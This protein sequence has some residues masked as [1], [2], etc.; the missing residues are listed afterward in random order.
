MNN[1]TKRFFSIAIIAIIPL[2]IFQVVVPTMAEDTTDE[3]AVYGTPVYDDEGYL[4][5]SNITIDISEES[6]PIENFTNIS[7]MAPSGCWCD[8]RWSG[9]DGVWCSKSKYNSN[10]KIV[11]YVQFKNYAQDCSYIINFRLYDPSG[12]CIEYKLEYGG[13]GYMAVQEYTYTPPAP[14]TG[15]YEFCSKVEP[16][17]C[18]GRVLEKC[19]TFT[20]FVPE[21][22][23]DL[24]IT[25]I[26]SENN[27]IYYKIKNKGD[28]KAGASITSLTV[29]GDFKAADSVASLDPG[30]E[31][32]E[33][34]NYTWDCTGTNDTIE[35]CADYTNDLMESNEENNCRTQTW[36]CEPPDIW[37]N[38]T[39]FDVRLPPD[40]VSNYTLTI[41][42]KGTGAL[43]FNVKDREQA[44]ADIV[45]SIPVPGTM[46]TGLTWD[47]QYLWLGDWLAQK[48]Y[49][50]NS[51]DGSII[52]SISITSLPLPARSCNGLAW[53]GG[54]LWF[55]DSLEQKIYKISTTGSL[56]TAFSAPG[57]VDGWGKGLTWDG[58]RLWHADFRM[59]TIYKLN[60]SNGAVITSFSSPANDPQGLAWDGQ[61]LWHSDSGS[62]MIYKLNPFDG[63]VITFFSAPGSEIG[64]LTWDGQY[65]WCNEG[66]TLK[67]YQIEVGGGVT[68]WL[69]EYP[70]SGTV[71]PGS[72]TNIN[73]TFNTT[74]LPFGESNADINITSND[75]DESVV[76]VPVH[77]EVVNPTKTFDTGAGSY[78]S[79]MGV[80]NGT[81]T[82]S[83]D[84]VVN[85]MYTY[86]CEGT[87]GHS[88][89]VE[90]YNKTFYVNA[91]WN[92]YQS[93]SH[94]I[95]FP[96]QFTL[97]AD[98]RYNYTII[99]GSYP[100]IIHEHIFNTTSD[101]E[102]TC[103][104]FID[105][106]GKRYDTWIPAIRLG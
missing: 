6:A 31:R 46:P 100:Q 102:I 3:N 73:I 69:S 41:G 86:A 35:V 105:A 68:D 15:R 64:D 18:D 79:I 21:L 27:T 92:G 24:M 66:S 22:K 5:T 75:P 26:W 58:Q 63:S 33:S 36:I 89:F 71:N 67:I 103:T 59:D 30:V 20:V 32:A 99:T 94:N 10:E 90:L 78:P 12:E 11:C 56:K 2:S 84:V 7:T 76:V 62:G 13:I 8:L 97:L 83:H 98:H 95:T 104:E 1:R 53:D 34:L 17:I 60:P 65:L 43:E 47:G 38:P 49:K 42:N 48:I 28:S 93:D 91:T 39:S 96:Q 23:P 70:I 101:G 85:K 25:N 44:T 45:K 61:Y 74:G 88:E 19:C 40:V 57:G 52:T 80:H 37:V 16:W 54:Y 72:Q 51:S 87:G 9:Q 81:V 77:L 4:S 106:N 82:P 50:L 29:D 14:A 55:S